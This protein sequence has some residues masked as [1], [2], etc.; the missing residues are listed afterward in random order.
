MKK[1]ALLALTGLLI[2]TS[3]YAQQSQSQLNN[4][5]FYTYFGM[6]LPVD[7]SSPSASS[8]GL[9]GVAVQDFRISNIAN[10]AIWSQSYYS[11]VSGGFSLRTFKASDNFGS[12]TNS[13]LQ[14]SQFQM[15]FPIDRERIGVS[16]SLS[17]ITESKFQIQRN[18]GD[19]SN[20]AVDLDYAVTNTGTGGL[21]RLELGFG[22][23]L[24]EGV[25][26]GYAPSLVFGVLENETIYNFSDSNYN[27]INFSEIN[28]NYGFGNRFGLYLTQRDLIGS[29]DRTSLGITFNLPVNLVSESSIETNTGA[30]SMDLLPAN[31]FGEQDIRMPMESAIGITYEFNQQWLI[32]SDLVYQNWSDYQGRN[33]E[34]FTDRLK[35]GF[36]AQ[37]NAARRNSP[38]GF[39]TR[40]NYRAGVSYDTGNLEINDTQIETLMLSAGLG[41][42]SR[43]TG[44]S[45]DLNF[46]FGIRGAGAS[47]LVAERIYGLRVSFN[48][49][50]L[51][52]LQ[53]R[54]D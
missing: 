36:G 15:V 9:Q 51:M 44:S 1:I 10:P 3:L 12:R 28:S 27:N 42:P 31:E 23:E 39:F 7:V 53:R 26:F 40:F 18:S 6:G 20:T 48:L 29:N 21:N 41:I 47:E 45:I 54:L 14:A 49:S 11:N 43:R 34:L 16:L 38:G 33:E 35:A 17:P 22:I 4:G 13:I 37:Y 30:G 52:F 8:M 32:S 25:S 50:E 46:D 24:F 2:S 5:S 19:L